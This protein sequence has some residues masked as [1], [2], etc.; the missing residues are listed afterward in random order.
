MYLL[1]L[2][3]CQANSADYTIVVVAVVASS[4]SQSIYTSWIVKMSR[5]ARVGRQAW[6]ASGERGQTTCAD[7]LRVPAKGEGWHGAWL[8]VG[9]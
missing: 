6:A 9:P 4:I 8:T 3:S 7:W 2:A 5:H 1:S